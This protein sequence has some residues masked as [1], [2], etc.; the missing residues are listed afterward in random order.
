MRVGVR[1]V[2]FR[3]TLII[4]ER[5]VLPLRDEMC[6]YYYEILSDFITKTLI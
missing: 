1:L 5:H 3:P 4:N 6:L 2:Y